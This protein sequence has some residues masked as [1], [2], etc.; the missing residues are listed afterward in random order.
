MKKDKLEYQILVFLLVG[1][2]ATTIDFVIYNY[3]FTFFLLT[4]MPDARKM[5]IAPPK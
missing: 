5:S 2:L 4:T 3:L 1:G